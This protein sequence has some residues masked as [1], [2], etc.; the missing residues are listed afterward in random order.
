MF[1]VRFT[2]PLS[3]RLSNFRRGGKILDH[4]PHVLVAVRRMLAGAGNQGFQGTTLPRHARAP[5]S[6]PPTLARLRM[7]LHHFSHA[8]SS[9]GDFIRLPGCGVPSIGIDQPGADIY[10]V[11]TILPLH[12]EQN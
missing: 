7:F 2:P 5:T 8:C 4:R 11:T 6:H 3:H 9:L 10:N 1:A 12:N